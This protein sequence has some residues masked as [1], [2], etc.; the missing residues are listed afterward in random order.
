MNEVLNAVD[1]VLAELTS[2]DGVVG[3][4]NSASINLTSSSLV[5]KILDHVSGWISKSN[6]WFNN[7]NHVP[8]GFVKLD[9]HSVVQLSKSKELQNLLWLGGK[10]VDTKEK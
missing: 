1:T 8:R 3:K 5:N 7:S 2:N 4:W 9:E 6:V 10:L